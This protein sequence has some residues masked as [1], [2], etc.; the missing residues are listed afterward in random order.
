MIEGKAILTDAQGHVEEINA[1]DAFVVPAGYQGTW[2][3]IGNAKKFYSIYE[4]S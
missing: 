3:T 2:E 4:Q 1:G